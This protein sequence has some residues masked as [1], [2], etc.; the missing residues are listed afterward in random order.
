[1]SATGHRWVWRR[2]L[3]RVSLALSLFLGL[4]GSGRAGAVSSQ[5]AGP[6]PEAVLHTVQTSG[7]GA[8][9]DVQVAG[10]L[11]P[12][13][14]DTGGG[15][16]IVTPQT[17]RLIGCR[18]WGQVTGFRLTGERVDMKRCDG[19]RF[20]LGQIGVMAPTAGVFDINAFAER[21]WTRLYG[22]LGLDAFAGQAI[23]IRPM[24]QEIVVETPAS[25]RR[26]MAGAVEVPIR[27]VRDAQGVALSVDAAVVTTDGLAWMELDTGN[28][29]SLIVGRPIASLLGL[30]PAAKSPQP[31]HMTLAG[32]V[33]VQGACRVGD[34]IMDGDI[35]ASFLKDWDLTLDLGAGR[36]WLEPA[37]PSRTNP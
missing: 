30:D 23:T 11:L 36:A 33:A 35:G 27:I 7:W 37:S 5:V 4:A 26:R 3:R 15:V 10:Q 1:M 6:R 25:L 8:T 20:D 12:F 14:F 18:P 22:S 28:Q 21:G 13:L 32:G 24:A 9:V 34:F 31:L 19:A 2:C 17:A 29:G 16:T